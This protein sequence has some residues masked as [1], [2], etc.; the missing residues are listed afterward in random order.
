MGVGVGAGAEVMLL[1]ETIATSGTGG[2]G[3]GGSAP[4]GL[5]LTPLVVVAPLAHVL[6]NASEER[7]GWPASIAFPPEMLDVTMLPKHIVPRMRKLDTL[8]CEPNPVKRRICFQNLAAVLT[9]GRPPFEE[10]SISASHVANDEITQLAR[11]KTNNTITTAGDLAPVGAG[12]FKSS[13]RNTCGAR[14]YTGSMS[15]IIDTKTS[16]YGAT[17]S[18]LARVN[19]PSRLDILQTKGGLYFPRTWNWG[20]EREG[21]IYTSPPYPLYPQNGLWCAFARGSS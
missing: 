18:A 17:L 13:L 20:G 1:R 19:L 16:R 5:W 4:G 21:S 2:D 6:S 8:N 3:G 9:C 14:K 12:T 10:G 15:Q 11:G 7:V